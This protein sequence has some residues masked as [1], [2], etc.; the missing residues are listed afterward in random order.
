MPIDR[1]DKV[2]FDRLLGHVRAIVAG[3]GM[4]MSFGLSCAMRVNVRCWRS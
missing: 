2:R 1:K 4:P 3:A